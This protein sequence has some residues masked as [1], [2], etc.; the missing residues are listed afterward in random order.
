MNADANSLG[1]PPTMQGTP[2]Q[3]PRGPAYLF[4][5]WTTRQYVAL[6]R[7]GCEDAPK[8]IPYTQEDM[9]HDGTPFNAAVQW[10]MMNFGVAG[11]G[12]IFTR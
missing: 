7:H 2:D 4:S 3:L 9:F 12:A 5:A 11:G 10:N 8:R 1:Y 6:P